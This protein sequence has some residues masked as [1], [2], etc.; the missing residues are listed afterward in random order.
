MSFVS[1]FWGCLC[2]RV[3]GW[4]G[5]L[6]VPV[7]VPAPVLALALIAGLVLVLVLVWVGGW[8]GVLGGEG[9]LG[10]GVGG[11][12]GVGVVRG[13][14]GFGGWS[15]WFRVTGL[16]LG[17]G[18]VGSGSGSVGSGS[19]SVGSGLG[20]GGSGSG[21]VGLGGGGL[22]GGGCVLVVV[23]GGPGATHDYLLPLSVFASWG[24]RVVHYDQLGGGGSSRVE[25]VGAGFWRPELFLEELDNL[26]VGLGVGSDYVLFGQSW[27]GMLAA[28]HASRRP[29]GLRGLVIAN[30]PVSYPVWRA[31]MEVLRAQLPP[32]VDEV[33]R[34]HEAA[35]TTDCDEYQQA[36]GVFYGRHFCRLDPYPGPL[37][38]TL[39][40]MHSNP[41]VYH[42]MNGPNEFTVTGSLRD[43]SVR[44]VLPDI[45]V[46]TLVISGRHDEATS[47]AVRPFRELIPCSGWT[48]FEDS[49]HVP[50][51][52]EPDRFVRVLGGFLDS[53]GATARDSSTVSGG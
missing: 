16:G 47:A 15:T 28:V 46:P 33:L 51:L 52:E 2:F 14:V 50:H 49:S 45:R 32:G 6:V 27:G 10:L 29:A 26:L 35:G 30:A 11:G 41:A 18:S 34:R 39:L 24:V 9:G 43:W 17:S 40:E 12:V 4:V 7:P 1:S 21:S 3:V 25:G 13:V 20:C 37:M 42:A 53:V 19:G 22:G 23:H 44:D 48:V 31:E 36:V 5:C 38:S 8:C